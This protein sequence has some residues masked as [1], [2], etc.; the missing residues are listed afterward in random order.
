MKKPVDIDRLAVILMSKFGDDCAEIA[1]LRSRCCASRHDVHW[2]TVWLRVMQ[3]LMETY[4][5][6]RRGRTLH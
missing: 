5:A 2:Q 3:R 4:F 1:L 6:E